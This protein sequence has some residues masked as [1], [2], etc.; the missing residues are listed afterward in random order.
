MTS[1]M[2]NKHNF[3]PNGTVR[4][5]EISIAGHADADVTSAMMEIFDVIYLT[6]ARDPSNAL[7]GRYINWLNASDRRVLFVQYDNT[8]TNNILLT[9][10]LGFPQ[11]SGGQIIR[12]TSAQ[13][14]AFTLYQSPPQEIMVGPFGT[15]S[16]SMTYR[17]YDDTYGYIEIN[18]A[19]AAGISPILLDRNGN[20][21]LGIDFA[22]RIVYSGDIDLYNF[23]GS[24]G[25]PGEYIQNANGVVVND[26]EKMLANLW[27]WIASV[28][29][30]E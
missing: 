10:Y 25:R 27:A 3:G 29:L 30:T 14:V 6:Y 8:G 9:N 21:V 16:S 18:A 26:A 13:S 7:S 12:G 15:V 17:S 5:P 2:R 22:R 20:M 4:I 23:L 1:I 24:G 11:I 28:A 19:L